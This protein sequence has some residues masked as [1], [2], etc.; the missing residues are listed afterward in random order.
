VSV[1][2]TRVRDFRPADYAR[3]AEL[4]NR[5]YPDYGWTEKEIRHEDET[6][7]DQRYFRSRLVAE[8]P[9][10]LV[11]GAAD[12]R[13]QPGQF[14]PHSYRM[15]IVVDPS[16][17][18]RGV[19]TMLFDG[20]IGLLR[21]RGGRL[22]ITNA[23]ESMNESVRF[24]TKRGFV[25][26]QRSWESRL[27][28]REFDFA[29][30]AGADDRAEREGVRITTLAAERPGDP[31]A[32]PK[33]Y[34]MH[35]ACRADVPSVD[36][37][38]KSSFERFVSNNIEGPSTLLDGYFIAVHDGRYVGESH[39]FQDMTDD[40]VLYQGLTGVLREYRGRGIAMALKLQT[41]RYA[42]EHGKR[43]IRTWNDTR[44]RPMLRINEAM[45]F[46][47]QPVWIDFAKNI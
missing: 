2:A 21:E 5:S 33:A 18:R 11:V 36:P 37:I 47:K 6:W 38:T 42:L 8:N 30:F 1:V 20:V 32:V 12:V 10:G 23:K 25:E 4:V 29:R 16:E 40:G 22:L 46:V 39:L 7:E 17:R 44:N 19:G 14:D 45:G 28:V 31:E 3:Y 15:D 26:R 24:L 13:H 41:V 34:E 27:N 9:S 43:E 35:E